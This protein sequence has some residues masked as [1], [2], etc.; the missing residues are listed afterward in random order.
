MFR[1]HESI[2]LCVQKHCSVWKKAMFRMEESYEI[3]IRKLFSSQ[4]KF[5]FRSLIQ[6]TRY[7]SSPLSNQPKKKAQHNGCAPLAIALRITAMITSRSDDYFTMTFSV[8]MVPS[9]ICFFTMK[10]PLRA[11]STRRPLRSKSCRLRTVG[12]ATVSP[13]PVSTSW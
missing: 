3:A 2:A 4:S 8:R 10:I 9:D 7:D 5:V 11:V 13:M 6:A 1:M 12:S